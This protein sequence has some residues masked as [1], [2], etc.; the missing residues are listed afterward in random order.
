MANLRH[1][2]VRGG[3]LAAAVTA[4]VG[5]LA[6]NP[7]PPADQTAGRARPAGAVPRSDA[8]VRLELPARR[9]LTPPGRELF[10]TPAPPPAP[11]VTYEPVPP[12]P[13]SAP[14]LPFTLV[15]SFEAS[16]E[17]VYYLAE[18]EKVHMVRLGEAINELYRLEAAA[19]DQL[20]LLYLP[21]AIKQT[22]LVG[23]KK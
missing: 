13:P 4:G 1:I 14:P 6:A 17:T 10:G 22:L 9:E 20:E 12:P 15:G 23:D 7:D 5:L 16:G 18:A 8:S 21:L 19:A 3:L 2:V 11:R